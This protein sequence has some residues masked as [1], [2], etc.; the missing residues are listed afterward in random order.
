MSLK[1]AATIWAAEPPLASSTSSPMQT[2]AVLPTMEER[3]SAKPAKGC[4][5]AASLIAE[6]D[7]RPRC[8]CMLALTVRDQDERWADRQNAQRARL[9]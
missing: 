2:L 6:H 4:G 7:A 8:T 1:M 5:S 3:C 9:T